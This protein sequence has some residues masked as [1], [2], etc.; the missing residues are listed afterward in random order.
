MDETEYTMETPN[1]NITIEKVHS[2]KDFGVIFD[3][4]LNFTEHMR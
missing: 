4:K 2:E 1:G 3:N